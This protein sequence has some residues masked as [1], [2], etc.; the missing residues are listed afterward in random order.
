M[1]SVAAFANTAADFHRAAAGG[2]GCH[3]SLASLAVPVGIGLRGCF[4]W[5]G[6]M[7]RWC[8]C[9]WFANIWLFIRLY[10]FV[11]LQLKLINI[12]QLLTLRFVWLVRRVD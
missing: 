7:G 3:D 11:N 4:L 9:L 6:V 2:G 5:C 8:Y 10:G 1:L 12:L